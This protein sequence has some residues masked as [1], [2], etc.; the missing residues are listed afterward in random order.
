MSRQSQQRRA[1]LLRQHW[2]SGSAIKAQRLASGRSLAELAAAVGVSERTIARA[3]AGSVAPGTA[4]RIAEQLA[5]PVGWLFP[6]HPDA[7]RVR[8]ACAGHAELE[9][10]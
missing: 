3:E 5:V 8:A 7:E 10:S 4:V 1:Y 6:E 9:H 2:G